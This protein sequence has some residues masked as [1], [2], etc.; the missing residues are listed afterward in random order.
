MRVSPWLSCEW[1]ETECYSDKLMPV[2]FFYSNKQ[3]KVSPVG[4]PDMLSNW[5]RTGYLGNH[6][7]KCILSQPL[8]KTILR[9][10]MHLV[11]RHGRN[12]TLQVPDS[13]VQEKQQSV[14]AVHCALRGMHRNVNKLRPCEAKQRE[15]RLNLQIGASPTLRK[16]NVTGLGFFI[17]SILRPQHPLSHFLTPEQ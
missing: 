5:D 3:V 13:R 15:L 8:S 16:K 11:S 9:G 17:M 4:D 14:F 1:N 12:D 2:S 6:T 7:D 10:T